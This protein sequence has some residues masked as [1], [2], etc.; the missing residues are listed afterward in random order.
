MVVGTKLG[1]TGSPVGPTSR[2]QRG[3]S[4]SRV[5]W[6]DWKQGVVVGQGLGLQGVVG[7]GE[8]EPVKGCWA[9]WVGGSVV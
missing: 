4:L 8:W 6:G 2:S 7:H 9:W 5:S 1:R 3:R